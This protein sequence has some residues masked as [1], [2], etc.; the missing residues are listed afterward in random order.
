MD[1]SRVNQRSIKLEDGTIITHE[2]WLS[3][4]Y[5]V[6]GLELINDP[7]DDDITAAY[8]KLARTTHPDKHGNTR[9][10]TKA[11][12]DLKDARD[13]IYAKGKTTALVL[14]GE[15][16]RVMRSAAAAE[17]SRASAVTTEPPRLKTGIDI[18]GMWS[19][20]EGDEGTGGTTAEEAAAEAEK[21]D[22][23]EALDKAAAV[24]EDAG[25][26]H[27]LATVEAEKAEKVAREARDKATE[28]RVAAEKAKEHSDEIKSL[29]SKQVPGTLTS[30]E[31]ERLTDLISEIMSVSQGGGGKKRK[32]RKKSKRKK[33]KRKKSKKCRTRRR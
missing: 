30:S 22:T 19:D 8:R 4:N 1:I 23:K 33:S 26:H 7:S 29:H 31:K 14:G 5:K 12:Q 2:K 11:F 21:R 6:L 27:H 24:A 25:R 10:A 9:E 28:A 15:L 17:A 3:D 13:N 20:E 18:S 16:T 32:S